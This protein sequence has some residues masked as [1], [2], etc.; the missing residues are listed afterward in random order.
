[1]S[2]CRCIISASGRAP[3]NS[4]IKSLYFSVLREK[5]PKANTGSHPLPS[6]DLVKIFPTIKSEIAFPPRG[7]WWG[8]F[9]E[10]LGIPQNYPQNK[11]A[12]SYPRDFSPGGCRAVSVY[13]G[14]LPLKN[15]GGGLQVNQCCIMP[16]WALCGLLYA[17]GEHCTLNYTPVQ[18]VALWA[19]WE[20]LGA[21]CEAVT[22]P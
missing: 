5:F 15:H 1:M 18:P 7:I 12:R 4:L 20:L 9:S 8:Y 13:I 17:L 10:M 14:L 2:D 19:F 11:K 22:K 6:G 16:L 3:E 21:S